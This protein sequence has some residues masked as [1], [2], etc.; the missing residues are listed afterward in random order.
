MELEVLW[1]EVETLK[2][3][4]GELEGGNNDMRQLLKTIDRLLLKM[5]ECLNRAL[6]DK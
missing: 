6:R 5:Q 4:V 1:G 3:R 2:K